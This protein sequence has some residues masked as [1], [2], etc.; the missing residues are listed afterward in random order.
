MIEAA[1]LMLKGTSLPLLSLLSILLLL[2]GLDGLG[3]DGVTEDLAE[4]SCEGP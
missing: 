3:R 4:V 1:I 2:I